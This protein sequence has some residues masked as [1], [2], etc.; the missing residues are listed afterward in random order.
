MIL[1]VAED[2]TIAP[3]KQN[4]L[5]GQLALSDHAFLVALGALCS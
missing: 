4:A 1:C 2:I 3:Y 5:Q